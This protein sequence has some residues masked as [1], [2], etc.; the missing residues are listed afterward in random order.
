MKRGVVLFMFRSHVLIFA[1]VLASIN[2][3]V[4]QGIAQFGDQHAA[5]V[6]DSWSFSRDVFPILQRSCLECH[7]AK[8]QE[9]QLR[10]D[11]H[12][13]LAEGD[14]IIPKNP[15]A[16][17]LIR[18]IT[19]PRNHEEIMPAT[20]DPLSPKH[21]AILRQ[22]IAA[23]AEWPESFEIPKHWSY[24]IPVQNAPPSSADDNWSRSPL[25]AF[26]L[27]KITAAGLKPS[28]A[29]EPALLLRRVCFD[30]IGLPPTPTEVDAF[31]QDP[32]D[33]RF[34]QVVDEL[35]KRPQVGE[36]WARHWLD[37]ARYADS[38][39]FQRDDLR[40]NWAWRDW[41]IKALNDDMPFDQFTVEQIA[42]DLLPDAT[43]SQKIATGFH[44]SAATN[45]EAGSLPEESRTEQ[46]ID[47]V[48]T[49]STVWLGSTLE[50]VQCHDHKYDPFTTTDYYSLLAFFNNTAIEA[51]LK[52]PRQPSSIAFQGPSMEISDPARDRER[53]P[54]AEK[55]TQLEASLAKRRI[56]LDSTIVEWTAELVS[57]TTDA[58]VTHT[59]GITDFQ[60]LGTT[61]SFEK[62][63]DGSI[64]LVGTDAPAKD[65]Y[66]MTAAANLKNVRA[67]R[68]DA[69]THE[70]LPGMGPGR[71]D[72]KRANFVLHEFTVSVTRKSEP[73][74]KLLKFVSATADFSQAK[75]DVFGA[76]D[77]NAE[78]GWAIA[79]QF[80]QPHWAVFVLEDS[81]DVNDGDHLTIELQQDFGNARTL[82]CFRI[83][84][85]TGSIARGDFTSIS[86]EIT[87][88][89]QRAP[90]AWT[91]AERKQLVDFRLESDPSAKRWSR[92]IAVAKKEIAKLAPDSTLVMV[93]QEPRPTFIFE[94][95]DYRQRGPG[96]QPGTPAILHPMPDGPPNRLT[97]ARWLVDPA[98]PLVAR[99][100]VNRWWAE[101]FGKGLVAT[102]EDFGVK[103]E[104][105]SHPEL[106][107]WLAV[108]FMQNTWSMKHMLRTIVLSS[109]YRQSSRIPRELAEADDQNRL[110]AR[111]PRFRFDAE[112]IR[113]NAL[114][115][116]GLLDLT[117]FGPP[118]RPP[119]PDGLWAKVGGQQYDYVVS[120]GTQKYRRGIY[121]VLKRSA[122]NPSLTTFDASARLA[123][124][125]QRSRTNT[126]LQ[127]LTLLNDPVYVQAARAF[128]HRV[129][130]ECAAADFRTKLDYA[131][132]LCTSRKPSAD[133]RDALTRL[134]E[135]QS[136]VFE[137][138]PDDVLRI[139]RDTPSGVKEQPHTVAAWYSLTTV[140]LNL[141]ETITKP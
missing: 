74:P 129:L 121:V 133:E 73:S 62:Q 68:L 55:L 120:E 6:S 78:S 51:D 1:V 75:W 110:L 11:G 100:T 86:G 48:N 53:A 64:L 117:Q 141:H 69:L 57:R 14:I 67:F 77:G 106:L 7:G 20:G 134:F 43:E 135:T 32:S 16:S 83:A 17:E 128:T 35:L 28:P 112:M 42:G 92:Q 111:G 113:D 123:C 95:G 131:F 71:G 60:S 90:S 107:D 21:I 132:Q 130:S 124:T 98:N 139:T 13:N 58:P 40:D 29:A 38:H 4:V 127:A 47:R 89:L 102:L 54:L 12:Q 126:P 39:G 105:P 79:P 116:S 91:V 80:S 46:L 99:V 63:P 25:D 41:V 87:Q 18:R 122:P 22:W 24:Q 94:R 137:Q 8:K 119:Q 23:G 52:N 108:E 34:Q 49:T 72:S 59:L 61:D 85:V 65:H 115:V 26:V 27:E 36:K 103:G 76:V 5:P 45:V 15:D 114:A 82:G 136:A 104:S 109:T 33:D 9:G 31:V 88:L 37:L 96:V 2:A 125:V 84:A 81:L 56:D 138:R 97:L 30:L 3:A 70:S 44:R 101:I 19:L 66:T 50:C 10:L 93:E 118:I 140:L